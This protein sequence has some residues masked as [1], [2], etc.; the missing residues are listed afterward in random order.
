MWIISWDPFL[1]KMLKFVGPI[2]STRDP[3]TVSWQANVWTLKVVWVPCTVHGTHWQLCSR[4]SEKKKKNQKRKHKRRIHLNPNHTLNLTL[5]FVNRYLHLL[6]D[7]HAR[8]FFWKDS[9]VIFFFLILNLRSFQQRRTQLLLTW[10]FLLPSL[11]LFL[12]FYLSR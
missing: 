5:I 10:S 4:A 12:L 7:Y 9:H 2:N 6:S 3:L 11:Y 1:M 8:D